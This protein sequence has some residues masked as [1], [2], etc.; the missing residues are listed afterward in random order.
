MHIIIDLF[1][2]SSYFYAFYCVRDNIVIV[3]HHT[4]QLGCGNGTFLSFRKQINIVFVIFYRITY[5]T[6]L[7]RFSTVPQITKLDSVFFVIIYLGKRIVIVTMRS[8][9]AR[10]KDPKFFSRIRVYGSIKLSINHNIL[11]ITNENIGYCHECIKRIHSQ[12]CT[13]VESIEVP[14][15]GAYEVSKRPNRID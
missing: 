14:I 13:V 11:F 7:G 8:S 2:F 10:A 9:A 12:L 1:F 5:R 4:S 3:H 15:C 6:I